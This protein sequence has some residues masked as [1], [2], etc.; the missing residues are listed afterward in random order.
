MIGN[1]AKAYLFRGKLGAGEFL[2]A[3]VVAGVVTRFLSPAILGLSIP[4]AGGF[5]VGRY[6]ATGAFL[7]LL[8]L[9]LFAG[10]LRAVGWPQYFSLFVVLPLLP[11]LVHQWH[12]AFGDMYQ[13]PIMA[14]TLQISNVMFAPGLVLAL[15][16]VI[17]G[18]R[19][20]ESD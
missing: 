14:R 4:I 10:R 11:L 18:D 2:V 6:I 8:T 7:A 13:Y 16:L 12:V 15:L 17:K 5:G 3:L 20:R 9:P 19:E 1:V